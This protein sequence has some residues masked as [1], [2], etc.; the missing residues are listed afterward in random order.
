M[1]ADLINVK[2]V[3]QAIGLACKTNIAFS[4]YN[5]ASGKEIT[6]ND[7][8]KVLSKISGVNKI[9]KQKLNKPTNHF[10]YDISVAKKELKFKPK[11]KI[12]EKSLKI[13]YNE[14]MK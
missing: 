14:M 4:V 7:I 5:I 6:A 3:C 8:A 13:W 9:T 2:D 10:L 12:N 1:A 11:E